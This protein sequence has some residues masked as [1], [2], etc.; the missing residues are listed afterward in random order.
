V[1]F[2]T[3]DDPVVEPMTWQARS[4]DDRVA[5]AGEPL[6]PGTPPADRDSVIAALQTIYDPEIPVN[7][8][9]LGLIYDLAIGEDGTVDVE[10][11]LTA[12]A[13]PVAGELP[14]TVAETIAAVEGVGE[15]AVRLVWSPPWTPDRMTEEARLALDYY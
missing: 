2:D 3:L 7:I 14:H 10:M 6:P 5:S 15:V 12:P 4:D 9:D 11:T 1:D 13:C 8:Y